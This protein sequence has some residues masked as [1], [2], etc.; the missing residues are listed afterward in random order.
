MVD[1]QSMCNNCV[2]QYLLVRLH[3]SMHIHILNSVLVRLVVWLYL[4]ACL[5]ACLWLC[6]FGCRPVSV[7]VYMCVEQVAFGWEEVEES[8]HA[9]HGIE[10]LLE[11]NRINDG[12]KDGWRPRG[13]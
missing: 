10:R 6:M 3:I 4:C 7:C 13:R 11:I 2:W 12:G 5:V 8:R 1:I 9:M